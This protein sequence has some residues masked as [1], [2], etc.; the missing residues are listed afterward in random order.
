MSHP[1]TIGDRRD[2]EDVENF[3]RPVPPSHR[4]PG[5]ENIPDPYAIHGDRASP[6]LPT[7]SPGP[8]P[9]PAGGDMVADAVRTEIEAMLSAHGT[10][11]VQAAFGDPSCIEVL[12]WRRCDVIRE[13]RRIRVDV[14]SRIRRRHVGCDE[15]NGCDALE[16]RDDH[17]TLVITPDGV[18]LVA[19]EHREVDGNPR[20]DRTVR[21]WRIED[22]DGKGPFRSLSMRRRMSLAATDGEDGGWTN[23]FRL[24]SEEGLDQHGHH[25]CAVADPASLREWFPMPVRRLLGEWGYSLVRLEAEPG[26]AQIGR[27]QAVYD[28]NR[29]RV[30]SRRPLIG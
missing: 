18:R 30:I 3:F 15:E 20:A 27:T 6:L 11:Y 9:F 21:L 29:T 26:A 14:V 5:M 2:L 22:D 19:I 25:L 16:D 13:E 23:A 7:A 8:E 12:G 17:R 28:P 10:D 24:P 4:C 1:S